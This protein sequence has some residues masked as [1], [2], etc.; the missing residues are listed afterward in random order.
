[1]GKPFSEKAGFKIPIKEFIFIKSD[2]FDQTVSVFIQPGSAKSI[3]SK[4]FTS[5]S[6]DYQNDQNTI[7]NE[8]F[9]EL[10]EQEE[11][12][13]TE[14]AKNYDSNLNS[15]YILEKCE[16]SSQN[17]PSPSVSPPEPSLEE[18]LKSLL[19]KNSDL[20]TELA[21]Y[22]QQKNYYVQ[23]TSLLQDKI[24]DYA[25]LQEIYSKMDKAKQEEKA[26]KI[27]NILKLKD[28][29]I[30]RLQSE[31]AVLQERESKY[32]EEYQQFTTYKQ[33]LL[34]DLHK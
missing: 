20:E 22:K 34:D 33:T 17:P 18:T 13:A 32:T 11:N 2:N 5:S 10:L 6:Y 31:L 12:R 24:P 21:Q 3:P 19:V 26:L 28:H 27:M 23:I 9:E 25:K 14:E 8:E 7:S 30:S 4:Y 1:M 15:S 16:C 29:Q